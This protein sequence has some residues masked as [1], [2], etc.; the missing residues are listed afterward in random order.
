MG[1][2]FTNHSTL[3]AL[4]TVG[5]LMLHDRTPGTEPS[6]CLGCV[7]RVT[8]ISQW[9][10][11]L[12]NLLNLGLLFFSRLQMSLLMDRHGGLGVKP[13]GYFKMMDIMDL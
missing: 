13:G 12:L 11:N 6:I 4:R 2:I 10:L 5:H 1:L 9:S 7:L 8:G 3:E